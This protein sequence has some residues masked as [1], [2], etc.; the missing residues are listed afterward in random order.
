MAKEV[1]KRL[2]SLMNEGKID[3]LKSL[4]AD[5][6]IEHGCESTAGVEAF[7]AVNEDFFSQSGVKFEIIECFESK[8]GEVA[9][10]VKAKKNGVTVFRTADIY[11]AADGLITDHWT[12]RQD[13]N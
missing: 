3:E 5:N 7:L 12:I 8:N 13:A 2:Y 11:C 4:F 1:V 6:F 10:Y 9:A